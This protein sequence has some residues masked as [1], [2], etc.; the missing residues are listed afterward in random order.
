[1]QVFLFN[2]NLF[3]HKNELLTL[4]VKGRV[5]ISGGEGYQFPKQGS[6]K[7]LTLPLNTNKKNCDPPPA[8]GKF[9]KVTLPTSI[10]S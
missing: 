6:R 2:V 8:I 7:I 1:M 5:I 3:L 10:Q 9:K 4:C